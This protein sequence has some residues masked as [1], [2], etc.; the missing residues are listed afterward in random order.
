[1]TGTQAGLGG[2]TTAGTA[3]SPDGEASGSAVSPDLPVPVKPGDSV[4][5]P[6]PS[7]TQVTVR[8]I[9]TDQATAMVLQAEVTSGPHQVT[10]GQ[11]E[12]SLN[13]RMVGRVALTS[14]GI[15]EARMA[16]LARGLYRV[17]A[18]FVPNEDFRE[19]KAETDFRI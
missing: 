9:P 16:N 3:R 18:R 2:P 17:T 1:M 7:P 11:V 8:A 5:P 14:D 4:R 19:S 6:A 10:A 12:F 15:A 13:G